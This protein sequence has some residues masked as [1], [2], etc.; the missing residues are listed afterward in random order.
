[1]SLRFVDGFD[2]HSDD[3]SVSP[4]RHQSEIQRRHWKYMFDSMTRAID[5]IYLTCEA[6]FS[7]SRCEA[8]IAA[9]A[10]YVIAT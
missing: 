4:T 10:R 1:M 7:V 6:D 2:P 5:E 9:L 8:V 3:T